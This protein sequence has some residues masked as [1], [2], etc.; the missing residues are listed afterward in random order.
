MIDT[1]AEPLSEAELERD[2]RDSYYEAV[3]A[4]AADVLA[5]R[6]DLPEFFLPIAR[7]AE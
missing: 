5:G 1:A 7:A 4:I 6:R 2:S 3:A